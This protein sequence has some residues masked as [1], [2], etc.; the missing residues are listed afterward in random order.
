MPETPIAIRCGDLNDLPNTAK[1][2]IQHAKGEKVWLFQGDM[3][4][5]KTTIIKAICTELGV[6]DNVNSPT[7][8]IV[9]EYR[10]LEDQVF[11]HFDFYRL[12]TE[13]EALDIGIHEYFD[14]GNY[15]FVEWPDKVRTHLPL[16]YIEVDISGTIHANFVLHGFPMM[17]FQ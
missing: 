11:Y 12:Q 7:F 5:G 6:L 1:Q 3:G 16:E 13:S 2:I 4:S 10:N 17:H 8:S 9:N 14:S 15:C